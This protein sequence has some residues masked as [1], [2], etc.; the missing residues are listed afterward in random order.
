VS[1][2]HTVITKIVSGPEDKQWKLDEFAAAVRDGNL[3]RVFYHFRR[4]VDQSEAAKP[5]CYGNQPR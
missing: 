4:D 2:C 3:I 1:H 5:I